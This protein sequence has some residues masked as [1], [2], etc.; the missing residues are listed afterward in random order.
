MKSGPGEGATISVEKALGLAIDFHKV[1][2]VEDAVDVYEVILSAHPDNPDAVHYLGVA[3]HQLGESEEAIELV[4]RSLELAPGNVNAINNLGNIYREIGKL[5]RAEECYREVLGLAPQHVDSLIN[6]AVSLRG[7]DKTDE[8]LKVI[9]GAIEINPEHPQAWHNLG[10]IYRDQKQYD[11]AL[12]AYQRSDLLDPADAKSS[13]EVARILALSDRKDDAVEVLK[14]V[15]QR[16]PENAIAKHTLASVGGEDIP[17]RASDEYVRSTFD[18]YAS[19]FDESLARLEYKAPNKVADEVLAFAGGRK[20]DIL[21]VGCGTGLCGPLLRPVASSLVGI[22]LSSAMLKKAERREVYDELAE[23]ELTA[24]LLEADAQYDVI[25]CVDTLVYFGRID[26]VLEAAGN[27]L[28]AGGCLVF[29]VERHA[30]DDC[31]EAYRLQH[32][33]RYSHSDEYVSQTITASGLK[34]ER[35]EHIVPRKELGEPVSGTL[36]VAYK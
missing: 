34:L 5:E 28:R 33:G 13:L 24:Y 32:H 7:L 8:A 29:T 30:D 23:A 12:S 2:K 15:L 6:M 25:I 9:K 16:D 14:R 18:N 27:R 17:E 21:D 36:V 10:N 11:D 31:P 22:D 3:K 4:S 1:G 20:L 26:E 19:S 35:L